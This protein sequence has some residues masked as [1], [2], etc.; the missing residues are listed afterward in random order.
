MP[1]YI[2]K[3]IADKDMDGNVLNKEFYLEWST[4]VDAP[5]T[6]GMGR[7]EIEVYHR[8][9]Y[10]EEGQREFANRMAR[11]DQKG[12][13]AIDYDSV[14]DLISANR[15]GNKESELTYREIVEE[16]CLKITEETEEASNV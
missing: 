2:C 4:I 16:Y 15:A 6:Y 3:F 10:G 12:V 11:V 5:V 13:S 7:G 1:K 14:E 9:R 8:Q